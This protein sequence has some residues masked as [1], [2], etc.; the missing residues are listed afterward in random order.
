MKE[1][2][3]LHALQSAGADLLDDI[4]RWMAIGIVIAG[5][6]STVTPDGWLAQWGQG[7]FAMLVMLFVGIP[8]NICA[9]ASTPVAAG[10]C[11]C[12]RVARYG[13]GL[14]ARGSG[15]RHRRVDSYP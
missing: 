1:S 8:M 13:A 5:V 10:A 15:D 7:L 12:G 2:R 14:F 3:L 6:M 4:S 11:P 9:V